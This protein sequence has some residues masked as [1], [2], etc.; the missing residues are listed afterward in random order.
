MIIEFNQKNGVLYDYRP[1]DA[2]VDMIASENSMQYPTRFE[3]NNITTNPKESKKRYTPKIIYQTKRSRKLYHNVGCPTVE[4]FKHILSHNMINNCP[5]TAEYVN[6]SGN[7]L[8][9]I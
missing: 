5:I 4:N 3:M 9:I 2:Y 1:S 6:I 7:F 8:G